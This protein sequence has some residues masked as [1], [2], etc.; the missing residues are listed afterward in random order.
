MWNPRNSLVLWRSNSCLVCK[1]VY[2]LFQ[3]I[4]AMRVPLT[5]VCACVC[6]CVRVCVCVCV[7]V[8]VRVCIWESRLQA[9]CKPYTKSAFQQPVWCCHQ[10]TVRHNKPNKTSAIMLK[11][12]LEVFGVYSD[13][14][15]VFI[16]INICILLPDVQ[17]RVT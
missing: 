8:C 7:C 3:N 13:K 2:D 4:L 9:A 16:V 12:T 1:K 6:V 11:L 14:H 5:S 10:P 17:L 15:L